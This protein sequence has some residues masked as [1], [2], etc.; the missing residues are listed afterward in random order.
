M[1][2]DDADRADQLVPT[3]VSALVRPDLRV[4]DWREI[5]K[6]LFS[7]LKLERFATF[8]ILSIAHHRGE[9]LHHLHAAAHGD[10]RR[11]RRSPS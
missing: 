7:A 1:K 5:N 4:R 3:L 9:L 11:G 6:T 8:V 10:A 2:V